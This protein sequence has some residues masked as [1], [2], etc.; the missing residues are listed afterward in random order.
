MKEYSEVYIDPEESLKSFLEKLQE[1]DKEQIVI[2][3]HQQAS[4]FAGQV[5]IELIKKY[6]AEAE[7]ELIFITNLTKIKNLLRGVGLK[8]YHD[9][10]EF[11]DDIDLVEP[12]KELPIKTKK[13][14]PQLKSK[15]SKLKK[16]IFFLI[17]FLIS[18]AAYFY[19]NLP[20]VTIKVAPVV[21]NK[22][23]VSNLTA[24]LNRKELDFSLQELPLTKKEIE[25]KT[26]TEVE[27]TGEKSV[28][29]EYASGVVT[30][31][32]NTNEEVVI[33]QGTV[34][35]TRNGI[36]YKTLSKAVVPKLSVDKMMD[37]VVGAQAGKEE[38]NIRALH[39]G[40]SSNVSKG[41]IVEFVNHSYPVDLFN[42][43]ATTGG[44]NRLL[45]QV[46]DVDV[47]RG[48]KKAQQE[49]KEIANDRLKKKFASEMLYFEEEL[50]LKNQKLEAENEAGD[51]AAGVKV[52]GEIKGVGFAINKKELRDLVFDSYTEQLG[53]EFKLHSEK[54]QIKDIEISSAQSDKFNLKVLAT[55]QVV[56][57]VE[58]VE[59]INRILG[60]KVANVKSLLD[61][62]NGVANY[63]ITPNNQVNLP[64]F[65][66]GVKVMVVEPVKE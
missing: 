17:I 9:L 15:G 1:I 46:R 43:E 66:Y 10:E 60:K 13:Q 38:V 58:Q 62:M 44:K 61:N 29:I 5:N 54:I 26:V 36:K 7:K 59:L 33:P 41:R 50:K 19:F 32:N 35:A 42:P 2:I 27:T 51:L 18:A 55:G 57:A 23:V 56:G 37:V 11:K 22:R 63:K 20:L 24:K 31:V 4:I 3:I 39:K 12:Q 45:S 14:T 30:F 8:V 6:A 34:L 53:E 28:G 49:L 40:K 16:V 48:L 21:K 64:Q 25:L 65:K 52:K 47:K